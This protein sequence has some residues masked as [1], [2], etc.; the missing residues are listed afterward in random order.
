MSSLTSSTSSGGGSLA[1]YAQERQA[2]LEAVVG[3]CKL[4]RR[5][6]ESLV[7][8]ETLEK[9]DRSPVTVADYAAQALIVHHLTQRFPAYPFIAEESSGELRREGKEEMRARLL[10]HVRSV[11][12]SIQD[13]A[14]LLDVIDRGGSG[15]KKSDEGKEPTSPSGLWWTLD[16]IGILLPR[17]ASCRV[18]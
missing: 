2:A 5:V 14:A 1:P 4:V 15:A 3:A 8:E 16:P 18:S 12:P 11:V 9:R 7:S 6:Q 17:T 10:E 13:E